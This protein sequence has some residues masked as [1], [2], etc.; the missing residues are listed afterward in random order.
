MH[1]QVSAG[2]LPTHNGLTETV[3]KSNLAK[4]QSGEA[5]VLFLCAEYIM[6]HLIELSLVRGGTIVN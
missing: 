3:K 1:A 6:V 4:I 5:Q 2:G